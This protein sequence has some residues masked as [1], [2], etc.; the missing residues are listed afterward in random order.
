MPWVGASSRGCEVQ[1][2]D[3]G[4]GFGQALF[5]PRFSSVMVMVI[6]SSLD[7]WRQD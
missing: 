2:L 1:R 5:V 4:L 7:S 3:R 6:T